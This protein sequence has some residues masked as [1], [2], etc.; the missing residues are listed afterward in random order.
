MAMWRCKATTGVVGVAD[1]TVEAMVDE[2]IY[3]DRKLLPD[4]SLPH[5]FAEPPRQR[6]PLESLRRT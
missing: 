4:L 5:R 6:G 3:G 1:I 2:V